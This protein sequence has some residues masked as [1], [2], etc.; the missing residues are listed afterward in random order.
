MYRNLTREGA[1]AIATSI[2]YATYTLDR[3]MMVQLSY[4]HGGIKNIT[5]F[6]NVAGMLTKAER[7]AAIATMPRID[8]PSSKIKIK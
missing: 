7:R 4:R 6:L 3:N 5:R 1:L 8:N 2:R